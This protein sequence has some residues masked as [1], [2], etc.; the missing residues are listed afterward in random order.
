MRWPS[1]T[2]VEFPKPKGSMPNFKRPIH[3]MLWSIVIAAVA[4]AGGTIMAF[5]RYNF[6]G[7][8]ALLVGVAAVICAAPHL[9][10]RE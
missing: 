10:P 3:E 4:L 8:V 2:H 1:V 9:H 6:I 7:G 5:P